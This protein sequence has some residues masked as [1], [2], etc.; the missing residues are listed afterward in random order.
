MKPRQTQITKSIQNMK[1]FFSNKKSM[2][3]T[4]TDK[5]GNVV[6]KM[7]KHSEVKKMRKTK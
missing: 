3:V 1:D 7:M 2:R 5:D 4:Y 6:T